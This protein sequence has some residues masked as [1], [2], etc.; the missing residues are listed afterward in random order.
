[1][2]PEVEVHRQVNVQL[3]KELA[4][5]SQELS[6]VRDKYDKLRQHEASISKIRNK[7]KLI[8][9]RDLT[10]L[11]MDESLQKSRELV[12]ATKEDLEIA[13]KKN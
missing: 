9:R 8:K 7:N 5:K 2:H 11:N 4:E 3:A 1:M 13:E 6:T 12:A 10:L